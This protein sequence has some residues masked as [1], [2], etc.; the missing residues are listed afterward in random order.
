MGFA[1]TCFLCERGFAMRI[2]HWFVA[3]FIAAASYQMADASYVLEID[4]DG[5]DDG[6]LTFNPNFAF[7]GDTSTASQSVLSSAV[8]MTGGDSIFGGDGTNFPDTYLYTY[9]PGTDGSN[10]TFA[11]GTP[12]NDAGDESRGIEAGISGFYDVYATW[13]STDNV[14][15]GL[16]TFELSDGRSTLFSVEIDQNG[17]GD[18]WI[19]LGNAFLDAETTYTLSQR[20]GANT[21]VSM[22]AAGVLFDVTAVPEPGSIAFL[23]AITLAG[24]CV[25]GRRRRPRRQAAAAA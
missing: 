22:R 6:S 12:L 24:G 21:F 15:G 17:D 1:V 13:P 2:H 4:I 18:E 11:A 19:L 14:S 23:S 9:T 5:E 3:M 10:R 25:L 7:G 16:T 8:G 20:A